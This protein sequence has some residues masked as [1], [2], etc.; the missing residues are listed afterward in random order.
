MSSRPF[1]AFASTTVIFAQVICGLAL[2]SFVDLPTQVGTLTVFGAAAATGSVVFTLIDQA[3]IVSIGQMPATAFWLLTGVSII[4]VVKRFAFNLSMNTDDLYVGTLCFLAMFLGL[5]QSNPAAIIGS[6]A[7]GMLAIAILALRRKLNFGQALL[8]LLVV[9]ATFFGAQRLFNGSQS[10][11][12][13]LN[14]GS[15]DQIYSESLSWAISRSGPMS[16]PLAAGIELNYHWFSFAWSGMTS[17][18]GR[19]EPFFTTLHIVGPFGL[20]ATASILTLILREMKIGRIGIALAIAMTF[21]TSTFPEPTRIAFVLNTSNVVSHI[22]F[23]LT[24]WFVVKYLNKSTLGNGLAVVVGTVITFLAKIP[25]AA[26]IIAG[27]CLVVVVTGF[28]RERIGRHLATTAGSISACAIAYS[29]F[30]SPPEWRSAGFR[31]GNSLGQLIT[32]KTRPFEFLLI[33]IALVVVYSWLIA[34]PLASFA[35][36]RLHDNVHV[37][38]IGAALVGLLRFLVDGATSENYFLSAAIL[39]ISILAATTEGTVGQI[40]KLN[41]LLRT[42]LFLGVPAMFVVGTIIAFNHFFTT[43]SSEWKLLA[44]ASVSL[45]SLIAVSYPVLR[46]HPTQRAAFIVIVCTAVGVA[47]FAGSLAIS[48]LS[49]LSPDRL[50][51]SSSQVEGLSWLRENAHNNDIVATNSSLCRKGSI[52]VAETGRSTVS[53]FSHLTTFVEGPRSIVG[54]GP[55][56]SGGRPYPEW[57]EKR[58]ELSLDAIETPTAGLLAKLQCDG[59][60]YLVVMAS[61]PPAPTKRIDGASVV[62]SNGEISILRLKEPTNSKPCSAS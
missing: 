27:L 33:A 4:I 53:A 51:V 3:A 38:L 54:A 22:W 52:C 44:L 7:V 45:G 35:K 60:T 46:N 43:Q 9:E 50:Y 37:F 23:A 39:P 21:A 24:I 47:Q 12:W 11:W 18:L 5:S 28:S 19:L 8:G 14:R 13:S 57:L 36:N 48:D 55:N 25:Y 58:I 49:R 6:A 17:R 32:D 29:A 59:V 16:N 30:I 10:F 31:L 56:S 40:V 15:D 61:E 26:S 42:S 20:F 62:Y 2:L 41:R 34:P 1:D